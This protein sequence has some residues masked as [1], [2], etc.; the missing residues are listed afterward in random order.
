MRTSRGDRKGSP[1]LASLVKGR[2]RSAS[3]K[4][5]HMTD[6]GIDYTQPCFYASRQYVFI[7]LNNRHDQIKLLVWDR[8]GFI[9]WYTVLERQ[10][11]SMYRRV[12]HPNLF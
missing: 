6:Y 4:S 8:N 2:A 9:V 1:L 7:F 3:A 12:P 11:F 5:P 10:Q